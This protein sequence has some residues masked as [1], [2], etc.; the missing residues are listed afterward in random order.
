MKRF[1]SLLLAVL[2]L[3]SL[4][5]C[6]DRAR[7]NADE[8][9]AERH[10]RHSST[11][12]ET[13]NETAAPSEATQPPA[14]AA[15]RPEESPVLHPRHRVDLSEIPDD[16]MIFL[17]RF[18]WYGYSDITCFTDDEDCALNLMCCGFELIVDYDGYP[19][20]EEEYLLNG[21]PLGRWQGCYRYDAEK[22][23]RILK[24]VYHFSDGTIRAI[25]EHGEDVNANY[26]YS[27]GSYYLPALGVGGGFICCPCY[28]ESDGT[29]LYLYYA[30]YAGDV[31]FYPAGIQYAEVSKENLDGE[32]TWTL[33][34]WSR[35]PPFI[36]IAP[37][38]DAAAAALGDWEL[39]DDGLSSLRLSD[40]SDG[41]FHFY[42]GFF[43]L[44]GFEGDAQLINRDGIALFS[45]SD[46]SGFQGW[47]ELGKDF[48]TLHAYHSPDEYGNACFDGLFDGRAYRFVRP[49]PNRTP[50][51]RED[52]TITEE[53]LLEEIER[54]REYYYAPTAADSKVVLPNGTDGWNYSREYY[55]H[56]GKLVFAFIYN[57][58]E[59]H[60]LYFKDDHMIRY[61]DEDKISYDFG[62]LDP[63]DGWAERAQEEA[64]RA[65]GFSAS[66]DPEDWLG[67]W[68]SENGEWI[69]VTA[70]DEN[71]VSFIFHHT[72]ELGS[73][74]TEYTLPYLDSSRSSIAEDESLI[75]NSG[76][77]YTFYLEGD[78]ILVTSRYPDRYFYREG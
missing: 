76:W 75:V 19:G 24:T 15:E 50:A 58:S 29:N 42:A 62:W 67:T 39:E 6:G 22:T 20:P 23:D 59:E 77:R 40:Y 65:S 73:V 12:K 21:D 46:G 38:D 10:V 64:Y 33:N 44:V 13:G 54:I 71:G 36:G 55:Y 70:A 8:D 30:A 4:S 5:A 11:G 49:D 63:F 14:D 57:G 35:T 32:E 68:T 27:D 34:Y 17:S 47:L 78:H 69:Q 48:V 66:V 45:S 52:F 74:D 72:A 53:E 9:I 1:L 18:G 37:D 51:Q 31:M 26:Y 3:C 16:L 43:R 25:R 61:I 56:D 41:R 60:R 28:A 2:M 7:G